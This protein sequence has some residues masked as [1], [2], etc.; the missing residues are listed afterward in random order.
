M[1]AERTASLCVRGRPEEQAT[2]K[3]RQT[4]GIEPAHPLRADGIAETGPEPGLSGGERW[5]AQ[6]RDHDPGTLDLANGG[7]LRARELLVLLLFRQ[8]EGA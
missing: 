3:L 5:V 4:V 2:V 1:S 7:R 8:C 6:H